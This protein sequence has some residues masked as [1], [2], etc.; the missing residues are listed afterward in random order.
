MQN[1]PT[2]NHP[3]QTLCKI[4]LLIAL[5]CVLQISESLIPH[6]IPGLRLGLANMLTLIALVMLGFGYAMEVAILRTVLSSLIMGT[7]MS[8]TF[9]LSLGGA[10]V[11]TLAMG[12]FYW[13]SGLGRYCRLSIIGIS[14]IG[15]LVHNLVQL[16]L[17]YLL[18]VKHAGIFVFLPWLS[19]GAVGTG[20]VVGVVAGGVCRRLQGD[21]QVIET[22]SVVVNGDA[23]ALRSY[24]PAN[25]FVHRLAAEIK[26][27]CLLA[28]A[29]VLL[30]VDHPGLYM[31][32]FMLLCAI[33]PFAQ[34]PFGFL[35]GA[36]RKYLVLIVI[37]FL[38]PMF[39]NSG[40][41]VLIDVAGMAI[42]AEGLRLGTVFAARILLLVMSSALLMRTT[43]PD[44]LVGGLSRLLRPLQC[45]GISAQRT[46]TL[47]SLA[48]TAMPQLWQTTRDTLASANLKN[49]KN[50]RSLLP[51]LS[52]LIAALYLKT[53]PAHGFWNRPSRTDNRDS[54]RKGA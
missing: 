17:A 5:A 27:L 53:Q 34:T 21:A 33:L 9:I 22:D 43:S 52:N 23:F 49:I 4:A 8:P 54:N 47:L 28:L 20:W 29:V 39:F 18:L 42:T 3:D 6:P 24:S 11:S 51:L 25:S 2:A 45:C 50:M 12:F 46:A 10:V 14:I 30:V 7:F 19:I 44:R 15:A 38:L 13:L 48:W 1:Q 35:M 32:L 26:L 36:A 31:G 40:T 16:Y 37:S 41:H